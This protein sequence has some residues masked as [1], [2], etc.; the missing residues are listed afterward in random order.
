VQEIIL[1]ML[2]KSPDPIKLNT[3]RL[4]DFVKT[5]GGIPYLS[6]STR[7]QKRR[8]NVLEPPNNLQLELDNMKADLIKIPLGDSQIL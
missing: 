8:I 3:A 4:V 5:N 6:S 2:L 7:R 1:G